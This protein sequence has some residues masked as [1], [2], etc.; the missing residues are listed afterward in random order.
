M[1]R[2]SPTLPPGKPMFAPA[3]SP[4]YSQISYNHPSFSPSL[5]EH[6]ALPRYG[7]LAYIGTTNMRPGYFRP[8]YPVLTGYPLPVTYRSIP[9]DD[10]AI[11]TRDSLDELRLKAR[12][13]SVTMSKIIESERR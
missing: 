10:A 7:N 5:Y 6:L 8:G 9:V 1:G 3:H 4:V 13:H 12:M 11:S 2:E